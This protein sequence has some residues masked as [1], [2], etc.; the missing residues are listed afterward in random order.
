M[1]GTAAE[2]VPVRKIDDHDLGEP[3]EVT[4][5]LQSKYEDALWGRAPEYRAWLDFV[6]AEKPAN[7]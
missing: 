1:T 3:G 2:L 6:N 5:K 4:R 7:V